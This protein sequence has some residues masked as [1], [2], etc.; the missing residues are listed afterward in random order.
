[1]MTKKPKI[2]MVLAH[3]FLYPHID[4]RVYKEAKSLVQNGFA[5]TIIC[6][7]SETNR[8][9]FE[10]FENI[11]IVRVF[12]PHPPLETSRFIRLFHNFKNVLKI[13][14]TIIGLKP[15]IIHSHDLNTLLEGVLVKRKLRLPLV[16]DSHE[17]WMLVERTNSPYI[18]YLGALFYEKFLL[19]HSTQ[20]ILASP[21]Q[22]GL[23]K[24]A[25]S[26]IILNCPPLNFAKGAKPEE[27]RAKYKLKNKIVITYHG[28]LAD[29]RGILKLIDTAEKLSEKYGNLKFMAI[30][31][32]HE[33]YEAIVKSKGLKD[34]FIFTGPIPYSEIPSYLL[35]SDILFTIKRPLKIFSITIAT[36]VYEAMLVGK[37][38]IGNAEFPAQRKLLEKYRTGLSVKGN[39]KA[40]VE[41][42]VKLIEDPKLR[43]ELGRNGKKLGE[44]KYNWETQEKKLVTL[45]KKLLSIK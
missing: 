36:K 5:V 33:P 30:G 43:A 45:Y 42:L 35:A 10:K 13:S 12:C 24:Y 39:T 6:R 27:T 29:G 26:T 20:I 11:E 15:D 4:P 14:R 40:I 32:N 17:D 34:S 1:M 38:V 7:T 41:G 18:I 16:Y 25:N 37:P 19:P 9:Q 31:R 44:R 2:A 28:V 22:V 3:D 23:A 21:G 8:K